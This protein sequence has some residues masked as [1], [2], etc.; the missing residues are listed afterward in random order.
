MIA[1]TPR[2]VLFDLDGTLA[3][4]AADLTAT[5][6][7]V[8]ASHDIAPLDLE[9]TRPHVSSGAAALLQL[10]LGTGADDSRLGDMRNAFLE[11]YG[12]NLCIHTRLFPGIHRFLVQLTQR[13]IPFAVVTNKPRAYTV[14][15]LESLRLPSP[16]ASIV[17][18]DDL[19]VRKPHPAPVRAACSAMGVEPFDCI[20][21]GDDQRD[22][23]AG[24]RAGTHT[25]AAIY[26]YIGVD[27]QPSNWGADGLAG[28]ATEL[29]RLTLRTDVP[30][31]TDR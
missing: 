13:D 27:Q 26:G 21:A 7:H 16:P 11:H 25:I 29:A 4:T 30:L 12:N 6:N 23:I 3:D 20:F 19:A 15:L 10:G 18:G 8:L 22:V 1:R 5:L 14:P 2:A 31:S 17:C 9:Q 28:S 24:F